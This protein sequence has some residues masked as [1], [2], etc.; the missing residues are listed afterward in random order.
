MSAQ[1]LGPIIFKVLKDTYS[2][3][4][5]NYILHTAQNTL[6]HILLIFTEPQL[7][8]EWFLDLNVSFRDV[9]VKYSDNKKL[10]EFYYFKADAL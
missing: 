5:I 2:R 4:S 1:Y 6:S 8:D 9:R 10:E 3:S 7:Y